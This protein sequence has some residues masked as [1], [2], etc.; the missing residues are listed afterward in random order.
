MPHTTPANSSQRIAGVT[1]SEA[2]QLLGVGATDFGYLRFRREIEVQIELLDGFVKRRHAV[3]QLTP[4]NPIRS[5]GAV[6][7]P[8]QRL[9]IHVRTLTPSRRD[10][11]PAEFH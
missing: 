1:T 8:D 7:L 11:S 6:D 2:K 4:H 9:C 3:T 10:T 5:K